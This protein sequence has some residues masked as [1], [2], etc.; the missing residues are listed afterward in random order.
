MENRGHWMPGRLIWLAGIILGVA[1]LMGCDF[2]PEDSQVFQ[3]AD[4][5]ADEP[6]SNVGKACGADGGCPGGLECWMPSEC[7]VPEGGLLMGG[8]GQLPG[9]R[10]GTELSCIA[11]ASCKAVSAEALCSKE[12]S[13]DSHCPGE[14]VC[15]QGGGSANG[16]CVQPGG[17]IGAS[18]E[19][20]TD[21]APGLVCDS[22]AENGYCTRACD[23]QSPCP[24]GMGAICTVLSGSA[25]S[26]CLQ[27]CRPELSDC[28]AGSSCEQMKVAENFVCEPAF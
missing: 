17:L 12:C 19:F 23:S 4:R 8:E 22:R 21:C 13:Q 7:H 3:P 9:E 24:D 15:W 25:G 20:E 6:D 18:C 27:E 1:G 2:V 10:C 16:W 26:F 11:G 5:L 28:H 14:T